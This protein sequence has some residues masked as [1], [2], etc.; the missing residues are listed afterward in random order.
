MKNIAFLKLLVTILLFLSVTSQSEGI[1]PFTGGGGDIAKGEPSSSSD[2]RWALDNIKTTMI[3][4]IDTVFWN[5]NFHFRFEPESQDL[6]RGMEVLKDYETVISA[7][8]MVTFKPSEECLDTSKRVVD[9]SVNKE[10]TEI[11]FNLSSIPP[12][13]S[14]ENL[15]RAL[16]AL[17]LHEIYHIL[18]DYDEEPAKAIQRF[19]LEEISYLNKYSDQHYSHAKKYLDKVIQQLNEPLTDSHARNC[20]SLGERTNTIFTIGDF[21]QP[22][23]L[24]ILS[25]ELTVEYFKVVKLLEMQQVGYCYTGDD[26]KDYDNLFGGDKVL[27]LAK[28][29]QQPIRKD[30]LESHFFTRA[31][32]LRLETQGDQTTVPLIN[33]G[34]RKNVN[35]LSR[36][37]FEALQKMNSYFDERIQLIQELKK[38]D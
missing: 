13:V 21:S 28:A 37:I 2:V 1:G 27:F 32:G 5:Y 30:R 29:M 19:T 24:N 22:E 25:L 38:I 10:K 26:R 23:D 20:F 7:L 12:K 4:V 31:V 9:A 16:A 6:R 17:I 3:P 18:G 15:Y 36:V 33:Y 34:S 8:D 14:K 35:S 11:C